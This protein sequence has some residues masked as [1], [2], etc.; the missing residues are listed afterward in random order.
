MVQARN[1][2]GPSHNLSLTLVANSHGTSIGPS[3]GK[4]D[5]SV[6]GKSAALTVSTEF[7]TSVKFRVR[8]IL[9]HCMAEELAADG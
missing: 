9:S 3:L 4:V 1:G 6:K 2:G 8:P 7:A 5:K